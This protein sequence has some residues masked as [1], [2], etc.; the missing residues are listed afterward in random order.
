MARSQEAAMDDAERPGSDEQLWSVF[1]FVRRYRLAKREEN[2]LLML[3]GPTASFR[4]LLA[5]AQRH[6]LIS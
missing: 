6:S 1:E 5:N 2:R 4:D 3:Y